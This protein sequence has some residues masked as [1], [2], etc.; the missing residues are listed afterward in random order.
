MQFKIEKSRNGQYFVRLVASNGQI[1]AN[2]EEYTQKAS[3]L[4]AIRVIKEGA[5]GGATVDNT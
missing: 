4:N 3:A 2:T 5:A 1:L